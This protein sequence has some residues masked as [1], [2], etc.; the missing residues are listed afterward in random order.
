MKKQILSLVALTI[1]IPA[2][3]FAKVSDF[4]AM[5]ADNLKDQ[6]A[7]HGEVKGQI[8]NV[9]IKARERMVVVEGNQ[10]SF[11]AP[12]RQDMLVFRKEKVSHRASEDKS[13]ERIAHEMS[14]A[15]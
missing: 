2:M 15:E 12:T 14:S 13:F 11:N 6:A 4:N 8:P 1:A 3:S 5:I 7:L 9:K 10:D